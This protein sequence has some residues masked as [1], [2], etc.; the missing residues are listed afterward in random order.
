MCNWLGSEWVYQSVILSQLVSQPGHQA[1]S[2]LL[3]SLSI[4][5]LAASQIFS[6]LSVSHS[7]QPLSQPGNQSVSKVSN[8]LSIVG[9]PVNQST[10]PPAKYLVGCWW[11][12]QSIQ[13]LSKPVKQSVSKVS[14]SLSVVSQCPSVSQSACQFQSI[15][16]YVSQS[17]GQ[18]ESQSV[19]QSASQFQSF[20]Q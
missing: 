1:V 18:S 8:S 9:H 14:D 6:G 2:Q 16:Q 17:V 13:P 11:V 19:S 15:S 5:L 10:N 7:I 4:S 12:S 20:S 3:A